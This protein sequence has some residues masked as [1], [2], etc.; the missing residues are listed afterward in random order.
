MASNA[1]SSGSD[2]PRAP[3]LPAIGNN[4]A[5]SNERRNE[6]A[7]DANGPQAQLGHIHRFVE[8]LANRLPAEPGNTKL[9]LVDPATM[10]FESREPEPDLLETDSW[11]T[12]WYTPDQDRVEANGYFMKATAERIA[13][14]A[15]ANTILDLC[16]THNTPRINVHV[17]LENQ[18]TINKHMD[19]LEQIVAEVLP[20]EDHA[21]NA[22]PDPPPVP[23]PSVRNTAGRLAGTWLRGTGHPVTLAEAL[24]LGKISNSPSEAVKKTLAIVSAVVRVGIDNILRR[25]D[26]EGAPP[27]EEFRDVCTGVGLQLCHRGRLWTVIGILGQAFDSIDANDE[28]RDWI[29]HDAN[30]VVIYTK[31]KEAH[32][33]YHQILGQLDRPLASTALPDRLSDDEVF[34]VEVAMATAWI[35]NLSSVDPSPGSIRSAVDIPSAR[36]IRY[37]V[38]HF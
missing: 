16:R 10:V 26:D 22:A 9:L 13:V 1:G 31:T 4:N 8:P 21:A 3:A 24:F 30:M 34:A 7:L 5:G 38:N 32:R 25:G 19:R 33:L 6:D 23:A 20:Q 36:P 11:Q 17:E 15:M 28:G 14:D 12:N 18:D 35:H 29:S 27:L 37:R 2:N